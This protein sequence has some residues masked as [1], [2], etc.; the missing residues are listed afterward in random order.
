[1]K[2]LNEALADYNK[3]LVLD[4]TDQ[5]CLYNRAITLYYLDKKEESCKDLLKLRKLGVAKAEEL[6]TELCR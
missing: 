6:W 1:M 3:A 5:D 2:M 4:S